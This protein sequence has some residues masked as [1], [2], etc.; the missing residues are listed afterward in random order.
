M[1]RYKPPELT[2]HKVAFK[3]RR[4]W[5]IEVDEEHPFDWVTSELG[6][7]AIYD[8]AEGSVVGC[9]SRAERGTYECQFPSGQYIFECEAASIKDIGKAINAESLRVTKEMWG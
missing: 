6:S 1:S 9:A 2:G 4:W 3:G 5:I 8:K 7:F